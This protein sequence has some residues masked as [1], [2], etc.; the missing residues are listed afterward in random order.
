MKLTLLLNFSIIMFCCGCNAQTMET[1]IEKNIKSQFP[2]AWIGSYQ[3][4][5]SIYD[6]DSVKMQVQMGLDIKKLTDSTYTWIISYQIPEKKDIR[7]Y[8]LQIVN[9]K[10]GLYQIDEKNGI[11]LSANYF[12]G[13]LVSRFGVGKNLLDILYIKNGQDIHF[14]VIAGPR[15]AEKQEIPE[16]ETLEIFGYEVI[17]Y[18]NAV[19]QK[20]TLSN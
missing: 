14:Q 15:S 8:E 13:T 5:L 7:A 20:K 16:D 11:V 10:E 18:Q 6:T 12:R 2:K 9:A 3:G 19:L 4:E 1:V 17:N